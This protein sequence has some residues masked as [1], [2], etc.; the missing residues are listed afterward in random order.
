MQH[1]FISH[2]YTIYNACSELLKTVKE[3]E[4][5]THHM[6]CATVWALSQRFFKHSQDPRRHTE[7]PSV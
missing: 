2:T 1:Q 3:I 5:L 6:T 7:L 4:I